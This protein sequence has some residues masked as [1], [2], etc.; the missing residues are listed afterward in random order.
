MVF[1]FSV[2]QTLNTVDLFESRLEVSVVITLKTWNMF[3]EENLVILPS[4]QSNF[5]TL[6]PN[7][8]IS[9]KFFNKTKTANEKTTISVHLQMEVGNKE[10]FCI[11]HKF[12]PARST[13]KVKD[14]IRK[15][16]KDIRKQF[17]KKSF[18]RMRRLIFATDVC[19]QDWTHFV[20]WKYHLI[21]K[22]VD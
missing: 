12:S 9:S 4:S 3:W 5:L 8:R 6:S 15:I 21:I 19:Q 17:K 7:I 1:L 11:T 2:R 18:W 16:F 13:S 14:R 22:I 20:W 10:S